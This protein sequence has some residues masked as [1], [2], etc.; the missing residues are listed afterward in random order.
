MFSVPLLAQ[1]V[2][3][4]QNTRASNKTGTI[5]AE[6]TFEDLISE[7]SYKFYGEV[8]SVGQL[9]RMSGDFL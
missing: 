7:D 2:T 8:R 5:P 9:L 1:Q 6:L 4:G 3:G